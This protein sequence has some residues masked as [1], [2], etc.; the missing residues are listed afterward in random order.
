MIPP[1]PDHV[2]DIVLDILNGL[3]DLVNSA[4]SDVISS[5]VGSLTP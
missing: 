5:V 4:A 1:L 2:P 3:F